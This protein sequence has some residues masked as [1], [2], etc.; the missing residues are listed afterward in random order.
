MTPEVPLGVLLQKASEL[1]KIEKESKPGQNRRDLTWRGQQAGRHTRA[2]GHTGSKQRPQCMRA[3]LGSL[4][5]SSVSF[6]GDSV[7]NSEG[8]LLSENI[9]SQQIESLKSK[10]RS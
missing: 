10:L 3:S 9:I 6:L 8:S 4:T 7:G 2:Y 1:F 5:M